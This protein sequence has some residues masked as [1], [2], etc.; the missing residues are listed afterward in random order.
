MPREYYEEDCDGPDITGL[1]EA[2]IR[3]ALTGKKG[4]RALRDV[5]A[6]LQQ[7]AM[8]L[9][10]VFPEWMPATSGPRLIS[11]DLIR[12]SDVCTIGALIRYRLPLNQF[13]QIKSQWCS[14]FYPGE[15][16]SFALESTINRAMDLGMTRTLAYVLADL[17]DRP[18]YSSETPEQR[19]KRVLHWINLTLL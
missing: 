12:G 9:D 11:D 19:Y 13:Q 5:Q 3:R 17:N 1:W 7:M 15:G 14:C 16:G 2:N 10:Y 6:A 18:G 4:Q 8:N